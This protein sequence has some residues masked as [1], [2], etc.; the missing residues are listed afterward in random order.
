MKS[1]LRILLTAVVLNSSTAAVY[2]CRF[3]PP[4]KTVCPRTL[5]QIALLLDTSNSMDGLISQAKSQLWRVVNEL[6]ASHRDGFH[7]TIQVALYDYG[8]NS[9]SAGES[10]VRQVL[11]FTSDLDMVSERL[12][13]LS[14]NG[15]DEYCGAV[16]DN[17]LT[18]LEWDRRGDVYKAVF[19][20]GNE[21]FTQGPVD[22]RN[23]IT[24]AARKGVV[25]NTIFCGNRQEGI[26]THWKA[27]AELGMGDYFAI[28][29]DA[30]MAV[31]RSPYDDEI[32]QLG[33]RLNDTYIPYGRRGEAAY[34]RQA[35]ADV[36][37]LSQ[38]A[39]GASVERAV[40]KAKAQYAAEASWDA[41]SEVESGRL[42]IAA[43]KKEQLPASLQKMEDA[44]VQEHF[45]KKSADRKDIQSRINE[46][47]EARQK[48][49]TEAAKNA[50][51]QETL[52]QALIKAVRTQAA[53][54]GYKFKKS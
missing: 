34:E 54:K 23:A 37:A 4:K 17:A 43:I 48:F 5:V 16:I 29:Q 39:S 8:N 52:D 19:I 40:Y 21:P 50:P 41:V 49:L 28:D 31:L 36:R 18:N 26:A 35:K 15:G 12:F 27:G 25:V 6:A 20:A 42:P 14:T 3:C 11:P 46:L 24:R 1:F 47:G 13:G 38:A 53:G 30:P 7:P 32:E 44:E 51:A 10:Y 33:R 45:R 22:F 9:I 2:A